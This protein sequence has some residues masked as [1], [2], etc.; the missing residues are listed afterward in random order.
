MSIFDA[1]L[2]NY[3]GTADTNFDTLSKMSQKKFVFY[4]TVAKLKDYFISPA[5]VR[6]ISILN[7]SLIQIRISRIFFARVYRNPTIFDIIPWVYGLIVSNKMKQT[8]N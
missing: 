7:L 6:Y 2:H 4:I 1:A 8:M 3:A 5:Y